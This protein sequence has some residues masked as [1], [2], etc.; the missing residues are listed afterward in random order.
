MNEAKEWIYIKTSC[1]TVSEYFFGLLLYIFLPLKVASSSLNIGIKE[2]IWKRTTHK[3][4]MCIR[5]QREI[6]L[7]GNKYMIFGCLRK[8][9]G[10]CFLFTCDFN[11]IFTFTTDTFSHLVF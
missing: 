4:R 6:Y 11:A 9:E 2:Y 10:N 3:L 8:Q 5:D 1:V 7:K